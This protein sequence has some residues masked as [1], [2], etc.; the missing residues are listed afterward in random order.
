MSEVQVKVEE[1]FWTIEDRKLIIVHLEKV[2]CSSESI[3][4]PI[5]LPLDQSYG[6][7]E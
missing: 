4:S 2:K 6:V 1:C 3:H 7:V 5:F